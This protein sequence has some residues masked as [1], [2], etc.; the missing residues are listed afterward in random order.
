M[1]AEKMIIVTGKQYLELKQ[2]L[3][4]GEGLTYNI[5]TD[6]HPEMVKITNIYMDTD[7]DFTRNPRQF[8][9]MHEDLN[10]QVKLEYVAE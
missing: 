2:S 1:T 3:E 7:P 6:K 8:A 4:S 9:R 5:G 10:V